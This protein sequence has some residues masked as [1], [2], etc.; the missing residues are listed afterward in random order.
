MWTQVWD[1]LRDES[2]PCPRAIRGGEC[3]PRRVYRRAAEFR[4]RLELKCADL[5]GLT[6]SSLPAT[7]FTVGSCAEFQ[8]ENID[9]GSI[10]AS[11]AIL[12][13]TVMQ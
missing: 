5:L 10:A 11:W 3:L 6:A 4:R 8:V 7:Q 13:D 2:A 1:Q 12:S 9:G